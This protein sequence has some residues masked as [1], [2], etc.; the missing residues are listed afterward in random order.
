MRRKRQSKQKE[1]IVRERE[2]TEGGDRT[3]ESAVPEW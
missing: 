1:Q 2:M 3:K